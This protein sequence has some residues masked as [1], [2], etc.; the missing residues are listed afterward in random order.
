MSGK[1]I[2]RLEVVRQILDG[3]LSQKAGGAKLGLSSRQVRRL[4]R[5]YENCGV[6]GRVSQR[7]GKPSNRRLPGEVK[8]AGLSRV[9][10][11]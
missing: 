1:E 3:V 11:C 2:G 6:S 5:R 4:R 10:E 9:R 7:R 8:D